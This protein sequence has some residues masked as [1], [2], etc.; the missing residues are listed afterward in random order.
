MLGLILLL[1]VK[2]IMKKIISSLFLILVIVFATRPLYA[3]TTRDEQTPYHHTENAM[4]DIDKAI[5]T[6]KAEDKLAL[7]VLGANWCHDSRALAQRL[8]SDEMSQLMAD[9][10]IL[11][12]VDIGFYESNMELVKRFGLPIMFGT[13][14]VLVVDPNTETLLNRDTMHKWLDAASVS[15]EDTQN[16]FT[17][18]LNAEPIELVAE[19]S[20]QLRSL[21]AE[22]SNFETSQSARITN[23]YSVLGPMLKDRVAGVGKNQEFMKHWV[24]LSKL[25]YGLAN[26]LIKL[27][28]EAIR[29]DAAGEA[30]V[31][32]TYPVFAPLSWE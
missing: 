12:Y 6:A 29:R 21:L 26:G 16:H 14:T 7:I 22:I 9:D 30:N 5:A 19:Q 18:L 3:Q 20:A 31:K 10:Y 11:L 23:G 25:R 24:P 15:L 1:K 27:R 13:P 2:L 32:L 28:S 17:K 4:G 8:G